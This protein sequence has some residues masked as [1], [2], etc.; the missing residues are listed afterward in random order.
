MY[1]R[2]PPTHTTQRQ[3]A[4]CNNQRHDHPPHLTSFTHL[5]HLQ[6]YRSP[7]HKANTALLGHSLACLEPTNLQLSPRRRSTTE[8]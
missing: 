7:F 1:L 2:F 8:V 4:S 3:G 5:A 6:A